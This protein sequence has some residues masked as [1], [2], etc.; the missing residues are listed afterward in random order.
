MAIATSG[1]A[2]E[3]AVLSALVKRGFDVLVPF[4]SGQAYDLVLDLGDTWFL[5]VQCKTAWPVKGCLA[6]NC[7]TTDH[8]RGRRSYL[9][10]ADI[11]EVHFPPDDSVY[12]LP[13]AA[14][15]G[16]QGRLRIAPAL[17]NQRKGV[18]LASEFA[19]GMWSLQALRS[20]AADARPTGE[21]SLN[22]A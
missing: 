1:N 11:F 10:L 8:G 17:N 20:V 13:V 2:G 21:A 18:K 16:F 7:R 12:L 22:F 4:G 5:R 19:I 6:F 9:G 3:A 14:A 15:S